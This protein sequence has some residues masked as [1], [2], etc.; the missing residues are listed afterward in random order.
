MDFL[1]TALSGVFAGVFAGEFASLQPWAKASIG[2]ALV[3]LVAVVAGIVARIVLLKVVRRGREQ[4]GSGWWHIA[5]HDTVLR[6]VAKVVPS[7]VMQQAV[8]GVP[9]LQAPLANLLHNLAAAFT[10]YH[11]ARAVM[12]LLDALN[13]TGVIPDEG[14][15]KE[16]D[17]VIQ[18]GQRGPYI[19]SQRLEIYKKYIDQ[20]IDQGQAYYCFCTKERLD[21]VRNTQKEKNG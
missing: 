13:L 1:N 2:L 6:R 19:Q 14:L 9:H 16:N 8:Y 10:T 18:K 20:L 21:E 3:A 7:I 5:L 15:I 17:S 12:A 4:W 11:L